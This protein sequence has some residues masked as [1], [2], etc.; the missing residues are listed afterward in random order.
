MTSPFRPLHDL[1][2][3]MPRPWIT[4]AQLPTAAWTTLRVAHIPTSLY[5][6]KCFF[7]S[8]GQKNQRLFSA[9]WPDSRPLSVPIIRPPGNP[10]GNP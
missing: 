2:V 4:A 3:D 7:L 8:K 9:H 1:A 6:E 5:D 10:S